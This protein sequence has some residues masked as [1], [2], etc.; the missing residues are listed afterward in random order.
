VSFAKIANLGH[1][2]R[3]NLEKVHEILAKIRAKPAGT[4]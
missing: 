3:E 1:N 4:E 2:P